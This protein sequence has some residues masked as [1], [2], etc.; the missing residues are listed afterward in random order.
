ML[1]LAPS[2]TYD[3]MDVNQVEGYFLIEFYRK[4]II[5]LYSSS[6]VCFFSC[7]SECL[8]DED[9]TTSGP[10]V[11]LG[12]KGRPVDEA[13]ISSSAINRGDLHQKLGTVM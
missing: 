13:S 5:F 4:F 8:A 9:S 3:P 2:P 11:Q 12:K 10:P 7:Y 6:L 1:A